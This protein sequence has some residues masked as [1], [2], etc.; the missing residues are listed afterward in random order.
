MIELLTAEQV[1]ELVND[2]NEIGWAEEL[3]LLWTE[4]RAE[5]LKLM[6]SVIGVGFCEPITLGNDGRL[7]DGHHRV[8]VALALGIMLPASQ[9][10]A[11]AVSEVVR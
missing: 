1:M 3:R 9:V 7:W 5:M 10:P 8:G 4:R 2:G 11:E 6:D